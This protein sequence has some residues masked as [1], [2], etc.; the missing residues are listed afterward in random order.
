MLVGFGASNAQAVAGTL[1]YRF[2]SA[3][4]TILVGLVAAATWKLHKPRITAA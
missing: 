1:L 3:V 4:P 2:L